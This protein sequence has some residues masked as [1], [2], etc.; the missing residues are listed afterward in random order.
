MPETTAGS[1]LAVMTARTCARC[2]T[3]LPASL[4][5]CPACRA[6]VHGDTLRQLASEAQAA[7]SRGDVTGALSAWRGA[8]DL[9]PADAEQ[10]AAI[11]A[12]VA[13]L[14]RQLDARP[15]R[16]D[17]AAPPAPTHRRAWAAVAAVVIFALSKGKLLLLGLTKASTFFSMLAFLGVYWQLWG[18]KFALGAVLC[19]YV[20][21]MGHVAALRRYGIAA[22]APMFIPG[23]GAFVR[24]KQ[25]PTDARQ[26]AR[27]GLAGPVWGLGA[28]LAVYAAY[29]ITG[30]TALA[31]IAQFAGW[32]NLFNLMPVWQ[33]DGAR[34][35]RPMSRAQRALAAGA[36][37][38]AFALTREGLLILVGAAAV[39][40]LFRSTG[41]PGDRGALALF[42]GLVGVLAWLATI[43]VPIAAR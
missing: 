36:V 11:S 28:G 38:V 30:I 18:W 31:A 6:L 22:S 3:H 15:A 4:L 23:L 42:V 19:I 8:L 10:W 24:L 21:E 25:L 17:G 32:L 34:G 40:Q 33:L 26:D 12:R 37:G 9:L 35:F 14:G 2:G 29:R 41:E 13:E 20:H 5:A 1:P 16:P 39:Y 43:A 27:V 7:E